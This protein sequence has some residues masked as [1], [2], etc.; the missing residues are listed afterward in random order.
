MTELYA[1]PLQQIK[2]LPY[3]STEFKCII[4]HLEE[5]NKL[6]KQ[7][8]IELQRKIH[9][10]HY[11]EPTQT[12]IHDCYTHAYSQSYYSILAEFIRK[13]YSKNNN[14][15]IYIKNEKMCT[16]IVWDGVNYITLNKQDIIDNILF[17]F[18]LAL[19][20]YCESLET[21]KN[22]RQIIAKCDHQLTKNML[23]AIS[24]FKCHILNENGTKRIH[25]AN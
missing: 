24:I 11:I 25:H 4:I 18:S 13:Y 5:E 8:F 7:K 14:N 6:L 23:S 17:P 12:I 20:T 2:E 16:F 9:A 1:A 21:S 10:F 3:F 22:I 19:K 15:P